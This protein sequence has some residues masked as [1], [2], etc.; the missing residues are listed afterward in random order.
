MVPTKRERARLAIEPLDGMGE[1]TN[2]IDNRGPTE[3]SASIN[4]CVAR[5]AAAM[6]DGCTGG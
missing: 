5:Q 6:M 1:I 2:V 3:T 4:D